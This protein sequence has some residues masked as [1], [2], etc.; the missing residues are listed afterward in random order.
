MPGQGL[1]A[2]K[3]VDLQIWRV[4]FEAVRTQDCDVAR[5]QPIFESRP[6]GP[7]PRAFHEHR[8]CTALVAHDDR[9]LIFFEVGE[10]S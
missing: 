9:I 3:G 4:R 1:H 8:F 2:Q 6:V 5:P 10:R 7:G